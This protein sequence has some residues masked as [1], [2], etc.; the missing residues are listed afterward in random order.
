MKIPAYKCFQNQQAAHGIS[1]F[2]NMFRNGGK[3][4]VLLGFVKLAYDY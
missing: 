1:F 2:F 3:K 4:A